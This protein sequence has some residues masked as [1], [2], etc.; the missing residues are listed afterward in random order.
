MDTAPHYS[1]IEV[2]VPSSYST[3]Y[4]EKLAALRERFPG[5]EVHIAS[6]NHAVVLGERVCPEL[7]DVTAWV[8]QQFA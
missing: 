1:T 4:A 2:R 7:F 5:V 8:R 3:E 6:V